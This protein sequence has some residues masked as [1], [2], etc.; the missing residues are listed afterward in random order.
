MKIR[1]IIS[2]AVIIIL[3]SLTIT[4]PFF[5]ESV[6]ASEVDDLNTEKVSK[7]S[8]LTLADAIEITILVNPTIEQAKL[9]L[10]KSEVEYEENKS[11]IRKNKNIIKEEDGEN[12]LTYLEQITKTEVSNELSWEIA[13]KEYQGAIDEQIRD[14]EKLYFDVL[15]AQ[16]TVDIYGE[17]AKLSK[18][19]YE[20]T[21]KEFQVG[22]STEIDVDT[23]ELNYA[24]AL[25][26][27]A[28]AESGLESLEMELNI[29]LGHDIMAEIVLIDKLDYKTFEKIN[30][31][32]AIDQALVNSTDL[33]K[34]QLAYEVAKIE[35]EVTSKKYPDI[36]FEFR[37]KAATLKAAEHTL[38]TTK[39]IIEKEIHDKYSTVI[40]K[41]GGIST[42]QKAV[43]IAE[44]TL[45]TVSLS[46]D[47]GL[48]V[49][50]DIQ[51]AQIKLQTEKLTLAKDILDYNLAV[52]EFEEY[53]RSEID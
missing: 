20:K 44:K 41:G 11:F 52:L 26:S 15:H 25:K 48:K 28:E 22:K 18:D 49:L 53:L 21:K 47:V 6:L 51:E 3:F 40:Q 50:T 29:M 4:N 37:E 31:D 12:S 2:L 39:K 23:S 19:L 8:E 43:E 24:K 32:E 10:E 7:N 5:T 34:A 1:K 36:V 13:K 38:D 27:L 17:N 33:L 16:K 45:E 14:V 9:E 42:S 35:M 46:Y 30:I